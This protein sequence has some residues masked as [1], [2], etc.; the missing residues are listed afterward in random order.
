MKF[1][2]HEVVDYLPGGKTDLF[3][4]TLQV[5]F[6]RYKG[7]KLAVVYVKNEGFRTVKLSELSHR[8]AVTA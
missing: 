6:Q 8:S 1:R 7:N 5:S 2:A 4:E 3:T